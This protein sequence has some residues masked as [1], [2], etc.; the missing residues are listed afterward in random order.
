MVCLLFS[1]FRVTKLG[2]VSHSDK[3][4]WKTLNINMLGP[5]V[6]VQSH[7]QSQC[8]SEAKQHMA[9][10]QYKALGVSR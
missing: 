6:W 4:L 8:L 5:E 2:V 7:F 1:P 10:P 3:G 9:I